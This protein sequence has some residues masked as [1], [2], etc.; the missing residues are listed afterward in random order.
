MVDQPVECGPEVVFEA[1]VNNANILHLCCQ[2]E[3]SAG[4]GGAAKSV[5]SEMREATRVFK[6][7][8]GR[9]Q[10]CNDYSVLSFCLSLSLSFFP[11]FFSSSLTPSPLTPSPLTSSPLPLHSGQIEIPKHH[12][13]PE[14]S[15]KSFDELRFAH[16]S[17]QPEGGLTVGKGSSIAERGLIHRRMATLKK[18]LTCRQIRPFIIKLVRTSGEVNSMYTLS[19]NFVPL[20][21]NSSTARMEMA[22]PPSW[23]PS[24]SITTLLHCKYSSVWKST[25]KKSW[26]LTLKLQVSSLCPLNLLEAGNRC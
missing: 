25:T 20:Y 9:L 3:G 14:F 16:I 10:R 1:T 26:P 19:L 11:H 22:T 7:H 2:L 17:Q 24:A 15:T 21:P 23:R 13:L 18:L 8:I 6:P 4:G 12:A 5:R